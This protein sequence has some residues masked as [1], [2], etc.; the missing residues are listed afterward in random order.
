MYAKYLLFPSVEV[1]EMIT[2]SEKL[3][4]L[5]ERFLKL[6]KNRSIPC[7]SFGENI[8]TPIGLHLPDIWMV[9]PESSNPGIGPFVC[10]P[11]NHINT[12]KPCDED[13]C[14]YQ[15]SRQFLRDIIR[16]IKK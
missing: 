16:A 5:H 8:K 14:I 3:H 10:L 2:S 9:P 6:M 1:Q 4:N 13:D 7:L 12:C 15:R 11:V